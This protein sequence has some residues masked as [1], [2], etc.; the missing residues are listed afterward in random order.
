M[1]AWDLLGLNVSRFGFNRNRRNLRAQG[2]SQKGINR[3]ILGLATVKSGTIPLRRGAEEERQ[4][5]FAN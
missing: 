4:K 3:V 2:G 5:C 1:R